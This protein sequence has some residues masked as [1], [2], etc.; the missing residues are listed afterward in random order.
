MPF[1]P[2]RPPLL[3]KPAPA[4]PKER[5][6]HD[7]EPLAKRRRIS[8]E[9]TDLVNKAS[10]SRSVKPGLLPSSS[11]G[12]RTPARQPL[13]AVANSPTT[14]QPPIPASGTSGTDDGEVYYNA[15]W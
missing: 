7:T 5:A 1:K 11:S 14:P 12:G 15:L 9:T 3:R 8:D 2:F 13:F 4:A 10:D 6:S